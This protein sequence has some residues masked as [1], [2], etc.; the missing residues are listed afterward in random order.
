MNFAWF[1]SN[2]GYPDFFETDDKT[3]PVFLGLATAANAGETYK[4][5]KARF[6]QIAS[7]QVETKKAAFQEAGL[8]FVVPGS[9]QI[10][11][12]PLGKQIAEWCSTT[13]PSAANRQRILLALGRALSRHQFHNPRPVGTPREFRQM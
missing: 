11:L 6:P 7:S 8:L 13:P 12:T 3:A 10:V 9:D 2:V 4:K 5:S 1:T